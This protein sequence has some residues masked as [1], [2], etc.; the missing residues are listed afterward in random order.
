MRIAVVGSGYVGLVA[1]ACFAE[2]GHTVVCIDSDAGKIA[3]LKAGRSI[4]HEDHLQGLLDRHRGVGLSFSTS[5]TEAV[6]ESLVIVIAVGT[7]PTASGDADLS[8]VESVTRAIAR[9]A[10]GYKL[11]IEKSTVPV[12][13]SAWIRRV[14]ILNGC[15]SDAFDVVSNPEFLREGTAVTD[16]LYPD[17][18]V[19]G[20]DTERAGATVREIYKPLLD[21]S[22][23]RRSDAVSKPQG[24]QDM[25]V[26]IET[27]A[28]SAELIKHASNAL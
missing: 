4:I 26:Y 25:A 23:A 5:L 3:A 8:Y 9:S 18:I 17:R 22:Y 27:S 7:P 10:E 2:L 19:A 1:A 11:I 13:T 14:M 24:N 16:F 15:S 21:G 28:Q 6:K 20:A 12:Y